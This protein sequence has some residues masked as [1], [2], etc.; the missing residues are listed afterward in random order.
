MSVIK[1]VGLFLV[2]ISMSAIVVAWHLDLLTPE[3]QA[4]TPEVVV[5]EVVQPFEV[6]R[7]SRINGSCSTATRMAECRVISRHWDILATLRVCQRG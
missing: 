4:V 6:F 1:H 7:L 3:T 5:A 2:P